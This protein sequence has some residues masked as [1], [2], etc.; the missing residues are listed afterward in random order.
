MDNKR[1]LATFK[2]HFHELMAVFHRTSAH[3]L[4]GKKGALR[5]KAV[6]KFLQSW[7]PKRFSILTNVFL[8]TRFGDEIPYEVDAVIHDSHTGISWPLDADAENYV[9]TWEEVRL[10]VEVKSVLNEK[11]FKQACESMSKV[12]EFANKHNLKLPIIALFSYQGD[13][14]FIDPLLEYFIY[15]HSN[16][17]PFDAFILLNKGVYFSD[18]LRELRVGIER[19]L[20]PSLVKKDGPSQDKLIIEDCVVS[21]IPEGYKAVYDCSPEGNLFVFAVLAIYSAAGDDITQAFL[22]ACMKPRYNPIFDD[23]I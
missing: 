18:K 17:Y 1:L 13:D 14:N 23:E 6:A 21:R 7:I 4:P 3:K 16:D 20:S 10:I 15:S 12:I 11:I 22:S 2:G 19:G 8:V 5:E 9:A